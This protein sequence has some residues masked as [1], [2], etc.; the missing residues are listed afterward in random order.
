MNSATASFEWVGKQKG[1]C[2]QE[3]LNNQLA[4]FLSWCKLQEM[5]S[6]K[7]RKNDKHISAAAA[8]DDLII[9]LQTIF[10]ADLKGF[11]PNKIYKIWY[12][13]YQ[14]LEFNFECSIALTILLCSE[15]FLQTQ[16]CA[17]F[18]WLQES[19]ITAISGN[20]RNSWLG[21]QISVGINEPAS[22]GKCSWVN[23][24]QKWK[25]NRNK[26]GKSGSN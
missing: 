13:K 24:K 6:E 10:V 26:S 17:S 16:Y 3:L 4:N 22:S 21:I 2:S 7:Y 20:K 1:S 23:N 14:I 18:C 5:P 11:H 8:Y 15:S 9:N 12:S 19:I 25:R